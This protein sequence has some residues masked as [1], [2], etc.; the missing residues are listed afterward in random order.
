[1]LA[2]L[3]IDIVAFPSSELQYKV[4]IIGNKIGW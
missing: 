3:C 1:M 2:L 4:D